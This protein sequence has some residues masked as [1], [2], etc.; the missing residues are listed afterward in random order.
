MYMVIVECNLSVKRLWLYIMVMFMVL[1]YF[2]WRLNRTAALLQDTSSMFTLDGLPLVHV[3]NRCSTGYVINTATDWYVYVTCCSQSADLYYINTP[4]R[5]RFGSPRLAVSGLV[6]TEAFRECGA[7]FSLRRSIQKVW[8]V[9]LITQKH[10]KCV[11]RD[12][13]YAETFK[14][15][16]VWNFLLNNFKDWCVWCTCKCLWSKRELF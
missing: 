11:E 4:T 5:K 15:C 12:F 7:W 10:S 14:E 6:C 1:C 16:G 9:I 13:H 3:F 8:I 2:P